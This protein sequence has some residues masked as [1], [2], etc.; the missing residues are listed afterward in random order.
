MS[1]QTTMFHQNTPIVTWIQPIRI[2]ERLHTFSTGK[3]MGWCGSWRKAT[4]RAYWRTPLPGTITSYYFLLEYSKY[5]LRKV[6]A[7]SRPS[8]K[9]SPT[10]TTNRR[11]PRRSVLLL[12]EQG[13]RPNWL[14]VFTKILKNM[15][16]QMFLEGLLHK[17]KVDVI[18]P[19]KP[20]TLEGALQLT[21]CMKSGMNNSIKNIC[22]LNCSETM[23]EP[24]KSFMIE[25]L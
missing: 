23:Q 21:K 11:C 19:Q 13:Y 12:V 7:P 1:N 6:D 22:C 20:R 3:L 17:E 18:C 14:H 15:K 24:I 25:L 10:T 9:V 8:Q 4:E 16:T 5:S 2:P